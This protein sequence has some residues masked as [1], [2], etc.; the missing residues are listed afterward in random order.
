MES[1]FATGI[2]GIELYPIVALVFFFSFFVGLLAWFFFAD[3]KRLSA[4]AQAP[5][6]EELSSF[7]KDMDAHHVN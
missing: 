6:E 7:E 2:P 1:N 5:F 4:L 3:R